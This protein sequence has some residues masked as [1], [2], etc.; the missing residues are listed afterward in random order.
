MSPSSSKRAVNRRARQN[1]SSGRTV[2]AIS[3]SEQFSERMARSDR[4]TLKSK[5]LFA[6]ISLSTG[7]TSLLA[8]DPNNLGTRPAALAAIYSQYHI[9][10]IRIKFININNAGTFT[11]TTVLGFLDD[12]SG[13]EGD[14]PTTTAGVLEL[15]CSGISMVGEQIPTEFMYTQKASSFWLKTFSGASGSDPRLSV[16]AILFAGSVGSSV[17]TYE[18]D[19]SITFQG[20]VDVG[21][22]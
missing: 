9:N 15:R 16:A 5:L 12:A 13:A 8:I 6:N 7:V 20:A 1:K 14:A 17:L 3:R 18:L 10:F 4:T 19:F 22:A 2:V 21:A 11:N